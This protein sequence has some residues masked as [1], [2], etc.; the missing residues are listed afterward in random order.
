MKCENMKKTISSSKIEGDEKD[1]DPE[2]LE[3]N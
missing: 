1:F 3:K 2:N